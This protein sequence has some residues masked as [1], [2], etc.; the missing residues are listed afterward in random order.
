MIVGK[1]EDWEA[2]PHLLGL[3]SRKVTPPLLKLLHSS[4]TKATHSSSD[5]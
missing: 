5:W 4:G 2:K 3:A 1:M